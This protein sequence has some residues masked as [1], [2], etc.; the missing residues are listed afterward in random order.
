MFK[1]RGFTLIE[2]MVTVV[3]ISILALVVMPS[4]A[5][6]VSKSRVEGVAS[7][8][9]TDIQYARSQA[10]VLQRAVEVRT[11]S[12]GGAYLLSCPDCPDFDPELVA[13][14]KK[15]MK[16]VSLPSG[17]SLSKDV[18]L[19]FDSLRGQAVDFGS[20]EIKNSK[21]TAAITVSTT[22]AGL[23]Q[24]CASIGTFFGVSACP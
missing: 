5:D 6:L 18:V 12:S 24:S 8:L 2:L 4:I 14:N 16:N 21:G 1:L 20:I 22:A 10:L 23:V 9:R 15:G 3:V 17:V 11:D 19:S 7:E 13:G